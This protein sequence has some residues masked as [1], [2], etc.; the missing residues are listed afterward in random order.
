VNVPGVLVVV[1]V[2]VISS[3]TDA[4]TKVPLYP[5]FPPVG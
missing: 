5:E 1:Y 4:T 2:K 3:T